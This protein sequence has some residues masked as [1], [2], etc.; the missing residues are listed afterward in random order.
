MS[1]KWQGSLTNRL[2]ERAEQPLIEEGMDVTELLYT[3]RRCY[4]VT[5]VVDQRHVFVKPYHVVADQ[6]KAGGMGHQ[7]WAYFKTLRECNEYMNRYYPN[8][9]ETENVVE[10]A[11]IELAYRHNKWRRVSRREAG[12]KVQVTYSPISLAFGVRDYYYDWE[13]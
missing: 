10:D 7:D 6:D 8:R 11:E 13:Y 1:N 12:G 3:D 2:M 4:Y 9:Y 5:K